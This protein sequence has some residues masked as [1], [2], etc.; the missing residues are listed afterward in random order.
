[1]EGDHRVLKIVNN[2]R[3]PLEIA[4][5]GLVVATQDFPD[6]GSLGS[7]SRAISGPKSI[8]APRGASTYLADLE[9]GNS[10]WISTEFDGLGQ[11]LYAL[12]TGVE[13]ALA[14]LTRFGVGSDLKAVEVIDRLLS[15]YKCSASVQNPTS[16]GIVV[17]CLSDPAAL[18]A[19][20][21]TAAVFLAP[22]MVAAP[23]VAFFQS[24]INALGDILTGRDSYRILVRSAS[25]APQSF[26]GDWTTHG[27]Q[28]HFDSDGTG[29][30]R[31][32]NGFTDDGQWLDEMIDV[33]STL[34]ADGT[35]L[36]VTFQRVYWEV[37]DD[38]GVAHSYTP[39]PA[40]AAYAD[41]V[42]AVVELRFVAEQLIEA[43]TVKGAGGLGNP[44]MCGPE[45]SVDLAFNCGA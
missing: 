43:T 45:V 25:P 33:T 14:L 38:W 22:L 37:T 30:V 18:F 1:M 23:V 40:Q 31:S 29:E 24:E 28:Y 21:G 27:A 41:Q 34:S 11:S 36:T 6:L 13:T 35:V 12:Q 20:F 44:Y 10:A 39:T 9:P 32:H 26:Y 3:Y 8:L 7:V 19:A 2:R 4:H 5:P 17:A 15:V 42:G 16:G